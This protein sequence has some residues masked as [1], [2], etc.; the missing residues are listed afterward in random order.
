DPAV[1][2]RPAPRGLRRRGLARLRRR[3]DGQR[4][5]DPGRRRVPGQL[6]GRLVRRGAGE[7]RPPR[8]PDVRCS[9]IVPGQHRLGYGAG[10]TDTTWQ[11]VA[12]STSADPSTAEIGV[13]WGRGLLEEA[14]EETGA[15]ALALTA[16]ARE[17]ERRIHLGHGRGSSTVDVGI[18][19]DADDCT[20]PSRGPDEELW[21]AWSRLP[22]LFDRPLVAE[23]L[24]PRELPAP[25]WLPD[26]LTRTG[27]TAFALAAHG[28]LAQG[29]HEAARRRLRELDPLRG[30]IGCVF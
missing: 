6:S 2:L 26:V 4:R 25:L 29:A 16:L 5:R 7:P 21:I 15:V 13:T 1:P 9:G 24:R 22:L 8:V 30:T 27:G 12:Q 18:R 28:A 10:V 19:L 20:L 3:L 23:G 14:V 11:L 17:L